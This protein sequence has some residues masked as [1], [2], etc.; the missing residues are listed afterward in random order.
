MTVIALLLLLFSAFLH[1]TWNLIAKQAG[2]GSI[3]VWLFNAAASLIYLPVVLIM[4]PSTS[5]IPTWE[6]AFCMLGS[7]L[8]H[9]GYF[10]LLNKGYAAGDLSLVYPLA[11]GIGPLLSSLVAIVVLGEQPTAVAL[12]GTCLIAVGLYILLSQGANLSKLSTS[13]AIPFAVV[14]GM[15]I[16]GYTIWDKVAVST[17]AVP[18]TLMYWGTTV[19]Q[20]LLMLPY[21][22]DNRTEVVAQW[23]T[24]KR[25]ILSVAVLCPLAY[26]LVLTAMVFTPVSYV[27]PVR[28]V[29]ILIGCYMGS[30]I[31]N[32]GD[33]KQR[34]TATAVM[35]AGLFAL[36]I[37]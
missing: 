11:R 25:Y 30:R 15:F 1:A 8:L 23:Q 22:I 14:T 36:S 10:L 6:A 32:E 21:A 35:L 7:A 27:A 5:L 3:F 31:L 24:K 26:I 20:T 2:G 4:L 16:A 13:P 28:E 34:L 17:V 33:A 12:A 9:I 19:G 29:S 18:P 37:G